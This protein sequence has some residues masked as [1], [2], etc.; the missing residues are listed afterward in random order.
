MSNTFV[1]KP[2][3]GIAFANKFK[4]H[5]KAHD[6]IETDVKIGSHSYR[7]KMWEKIDKNGNKFISFNVQDNVEAELE[8]HERAMEKMRESGDKEPERGIHGENELAK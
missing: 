4:N 6:F 8:R 2:G 3:N 7:V 1:K 5:P